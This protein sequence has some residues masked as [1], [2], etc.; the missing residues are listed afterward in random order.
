VDG[1][2]DLSQSGGV[3]AA[4]VLELLNRRLQLIGSPIHPRDETRLQISESL[5]EQGTIV[6]HRVRLSRPGDLYNRVTKVRHE[7]RSFKLNSGGIPRIP[8]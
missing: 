4:T 8:S 3:V 7:L 6:T 5:V 2:T 1:L